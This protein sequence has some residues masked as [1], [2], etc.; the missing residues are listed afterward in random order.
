MLFKCTTCGKTLQVP[1]TAAGLTVTCP[2]CQARVAVPGGEPAAVQEPGTQNPKPKFGMTPLDEPA[3]EGQRRPCPMCGEMILV[4]AIKCRYCGE[5]FDESLRRAEGAKGGPLASRLARL[6]AAILDTIIMGLGALPGFFI[7]FQTKA[8]LKF[9]GTGLYVM[10]AGVGV[11]LI[12]QMVLLSTRGQTLGKMAA[13][14]RI[15]RYSDGGDVGF[16]TAVLLRWIVPGLIG[17]IPVVGGL[18]GL[19]DVLFIFGEER[20]CIHDYIAGTKVVP[21]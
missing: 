10:V 2:E 7:L 11:I 8:D 3:D 12:I 1:D 4:E 5:I 19:L 13:G 9:A 15:V 16:V 14:V 17:A 6:G 20:R 21:A 18:F